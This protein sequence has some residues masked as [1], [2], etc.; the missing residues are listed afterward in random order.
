MRFHLIILLLVTFLCLCKSQR[1]SPCPEVF[2]Y[3]VQNHQELNKW[4]GVINLNTDVDLYGVSVRII[5]D[6][7]AKNLGVSLKSFYY[8]C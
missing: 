3:E 1:P 6:Q 2:Y 5:L 7:R 8:Y 4:F